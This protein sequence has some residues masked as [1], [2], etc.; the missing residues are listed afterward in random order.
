[1]S[2]TNRQQLLVEIKNWITQSGFQFN[3]MPQSNHDFVITF[4]E[5]KNLPELQII[6]QK[7]ENAYLLIVG[8]VRIPE[9]DRATLKAQGESEFSNFIWDIKLNLLRMGVDFT[10]L[11]P[12]E[13][14]P[15]A[16]EAQKRLYINQAN[17]TSFYDA[18]TKV[19]QAL[20]SVIWTYK[21]TLGP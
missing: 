3:S 21:R 12:D 16:W 5:T 4:Q 17:I 20:I 1:L 14:D 8:L 13:K 15:E 6:H 11:G 10:V 18:C 9:N 19:K 7:S 2:L